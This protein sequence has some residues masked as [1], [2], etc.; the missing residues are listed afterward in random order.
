MLYDNVQF[1][2]EVFVAVTDYCRTI[3]SDG[4]SK[5]NYG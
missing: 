3:G 4:L 5:E 2:V 1:E